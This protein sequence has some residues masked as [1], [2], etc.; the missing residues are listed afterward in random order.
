MPKLRAGWWCACSLAL[1]GVSTADASPGKLAVQRPPEIDGVLNSD[2]YGYDVTC[3]INGHDL[4]IK[5]GQSENQREYAEGSKSAGGFRSEERGKYALLH[6]GPNTVTITYKRK[7]PR[8]PFG[9]DVSLEVLGY[10][11]PLFY[12]HL[13]PAI[14]TPEPSRACSRSR[15]RSSPGSD[16]LS[17]RH[18]TPRPRA[19]YLSIRPPEEMGC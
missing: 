16:R 8:E 19:C 11:A 5:G 14:A 6:I 2:S 13:A 18:R 9:L 7:L 1:T 10:P 4:G 15:P 3:V 17:S 12:A